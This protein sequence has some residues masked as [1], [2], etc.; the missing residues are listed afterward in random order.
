MFEN[1]QK[2]RL[3]SKL[4][5][6]SQNWDVLKSYLLEKFQRENQILA[7]QNI[8]Q[9]GITEDNESLIDRRD[10]I[11][12]SL[13]EIDKLILFNKNELEKGINELKIFNEINEGKKLSSEF[14][15]TCA[16]LNVSV[17]KLS[18]LK[19]VLKAYV[20]G[21]YSDSIINQKLGRVGMNYHQYQEKLK[22]DQQNNPNGQEDKEKRIKKDI[23]ETLADLDFK[24]TE[25]GK[26]AAKYSIK[27]TNVSVYMEKDKD[28]RKVFEIYVKD[29]KKG[30]VEEYKNLNTDDLSKQLKLINRDAEM[31]EDTEKMYNKMPLT[32][33]E[34]DRKWGNVGFTYT[35]HKE[36]LDLIVKIREDS[37]KKN[38]R[39]NLYV[40]D[41]LTKKRKSFTNL[42]LYQVH[43]E[44]LKYDL[45]P[46]LDNTLDKEQERQ[47]SEILLKEKHGEDL[48]EHK[49]SSKYKSLSFDRL[50]WTGSTG[51]AQYTKL[52][53]G[54][55]NLKISRYKGK[56][57]LNIS[58]REPYKVEQVRDLSVGDV[59]RFLDKFDSNYD[60][61][62]TWENTKYSDIKGLENA[63]FINNEATFKD[64]N[65][66]SI[67]Y[68]K[69]DNKT[70]TVKIFSPKGILTGMDAFPIDKMEDAIKEYDLPNSKEESQKQNFKQSDIVPSD[71]PSA[72]SVVVSYNS[73]EDLYSLPEMKK[74]E[75]LSQESLSKYFKDFEKLGLG[76]SAQDTNKKELYTWAYSGGLRNWVD[77][78]PL[79]NQEGMNT[80]KILENIN[81]KYIENIKNSPVYKESGAQTPDISWLKSQIINNYY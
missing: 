54:N 79:S 5:K 16:K 24:E 21:V 7:C 12:E 25:S 57:T 78:M 64:K 63:K 56:Y 71:Y 66:N 34:L 67:V 41:V 26:I 32:P 37:D 48:E 45:N 35:F 52:Q 42:D 76:N 68:H 15:T 70:V 73:P 10:N 77:S 74:K 58:R 65:N 43:K 8:I 22:K 51:D 11:V 40:S 30:R 55:L 6:I 20:E 36:N 46:K 29:P 60:F 69:N 2:N 62:A 19:E 27:N 28:N 49:T 13:I 80:N 47:F 3:E 81:K 50:Q 4:V 1:I 9:K 61:S 53:E 18:F 75:S 17:N 14:I 44:L 31:G 33:E 39:L 72:K 23:P 59:S 38:P